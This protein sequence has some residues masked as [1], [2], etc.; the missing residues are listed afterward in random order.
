MSFQTPHSKNSLQGSEPAIVGRRWLVA[1]AAG[2]VL[3]AATVAPGGALAAIAHRR[4]T[5]HVRSGHLVPRATPTQTID[6]QTD[7]QDAGD[8]LNTGCA[9]VSTSGQQVTLP[10]NCAWQATSP[11]TNGDGPPQIL[12]DALY[13]C[14]D[15]SNE[16]AY[17]ETA[18]G[19]SDER[20][21]TTSISETLSVEVGLGFLGFE[22]ATAEFEAFSK[23]AESFSTE[24]TTTNAVAVP[25]GWKGWTETELLTASVT[26][27]AYIT[28]GIN[29]LIEVKD[30]DLNFP[31]YQDPN[32]SNDSPILYIGYRTPMTQD[33]INSHCNAS[34]GL[35][36]TKRGA[37][38]PVRP[39]A[40][41]AG[42]LKL[43]LCT[44]R[45]RCATRK[46]TGTRPPG[47]HRATVILS[48]GGRTYA[49][50]T[51]TRGRIRLTLRR[52]LKI[53][54]YTLTIREHPRASRR[55]RRLA[56]TEIRTIVPIAI[57]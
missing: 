54:R 48:R 15:S 16:Q 41:P 7:P 28:Q 53:G 25:P 18:V 22:K 1:L 55:R 57:R 34:K 33:D 43:T 3:A 38:R 44:R 31:G 47:I 50:G 40:A 9:N 8:A 26:G 13:N 52:P 23:Q 56:R 45:G 27:N 14:S 21:Q 36:G 35:G 49:A 29:N 20:E 42:R 32:T 17:S 46:A 37:P 51:D 30:I 11:I 10:P 5:A 19:V 2:G 12:G 6:A 24:V 39:L 4:V